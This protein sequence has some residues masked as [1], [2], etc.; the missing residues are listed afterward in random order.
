MGEVHGVAYHSTSECY[1]A[2]TSTLVDFELPKEEDH[3]HPNWAKEEIV[4]KPT[5][6]QSHL[7]LINPVNWSVIHEIELDPFEIIMCTKTLNLEVSEITNERKQ[8]IVVGTGISKGEDL[9]IKG[10]IHVFD[11]VSV[12][13]E[14]DRPET[15]RRLKLIAREEIARGAITCISEIGYTEEPYKMMLFGKSATRPSPAAPLDICPR[16]SPPHEHDSAPSHQ[17]RNSTS[18]YSRRHGNRCRRYD[19]RARDPHDIQHRLY[20]SPLAPIRSSVP[21]TQHSVQPSHQHTLS[22]LWPQ[23]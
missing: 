19:S 11:V 8:C 9:A 7:K 20:L 4:F 21:T 15:N 10:R 5:M 3:H 2:A 17:S 14:Q 12:V 6:E 16:R 18:S 23:S 1:V 13:P 22:C